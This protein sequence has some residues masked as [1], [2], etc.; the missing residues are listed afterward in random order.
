MT[1]MPL[2]APDPGTP[3][4]VAGGP[5]RIIL[6]LGIVAGLLLL[7][8]VAVV[9][10][11]IGRGSAEPGAGETPTPTLTSSESPTPT[12]SAEPEQTQPPVDNSTRFTNFSA[13]LTV[14]C[15]P[16][17]EQDKPEITFSWTAA[18]AVEAWY[19]PSDEDAKDDNYM[20]FPNASAGTNNDL[21]DEHLFPC[22]HRQFMDMT[23]TLVAPNGQ[24]VSEHVVYEDVN[25]QG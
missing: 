19:T 5:N 15:D 20:Q 17:G 22:N 21:T 6:I 12:V 23:I 2:P 18:N 16:T 10:L 14:E 9:F 8:V 1:T 11:L 13:D 25:W 3:P 7:T 4:P 24:H